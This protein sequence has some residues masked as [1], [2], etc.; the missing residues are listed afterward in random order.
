ML[1][2]SRVK[3]TQTCGNELVE[4]L[5]LSSQAGSTALSAAK[6]AMPPAIRCVVLAYAVWFV[7]C[8]RLGHVYVSPD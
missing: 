6:R 8:T 4:P 3:L 2:V 5:Q 1:P 7:V